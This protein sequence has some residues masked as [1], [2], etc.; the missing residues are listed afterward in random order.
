MQTHNSELLD[1]AR[2]AN[3][4]RAYTYKRQKTTHLRRFDTD[5]RM[6]LLYLIVVNENRVEWG[7][8]HYLDV[9]STSPQSN[10]SMHSFVRELIKDQ[11][12]IVC[13]E[14]KLTSK[15]LVLSELLRQ[16]LH[17]YQTLQR[18]EVSKDLS[19]DEV[20]SLIDVF[21]QRVNG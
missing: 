5:T 10:S 7:I 19:N 14:H 21:K 11:A 13:T 15:H 17:K 18:A 12:L 16:E 2:F 20:N 6:E 9:L 4:L 8:S 1:S 3:R